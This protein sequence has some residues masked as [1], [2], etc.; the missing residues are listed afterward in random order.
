M[1][2]I[3]FSSRIFPVYKAYFFNFWLSNLLAVI[4]NDL[5][6][7]SLYKAY[8]DLALIKIVFKDVENSI[9]TPIDATIAEKYTQWLRY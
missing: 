8:F 1:I 9:S 7:N 3:F 6:E 2:T 4:L 5:C